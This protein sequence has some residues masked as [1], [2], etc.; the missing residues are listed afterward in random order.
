MHDPMN[1]PYLR[2]VN[3]GRRDAWQGDVQW[4]AADWSNELCG[5][6]GEAANIVKKLRRLETGTVVRESEQDVKDLVNLLGMEL[7][8]V[9]ICVDLLA[10]HFDIDLESFLIYKFNRTTDKMGLDRRHKLATT[11]SGYE[12]H[13]GSVYP[14]DPT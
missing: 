7:A 9:L 3:R 1:F 14:K 6:V 5:E 8:D 4:T 13:G 11:N 2:V 12:G 10:M